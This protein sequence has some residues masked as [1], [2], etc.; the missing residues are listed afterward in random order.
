MRHNAERTDGRPALGRAARVQL[1]VDSKDSAR[2][3]SRMNAAISEPM[4]HSHRTCMDVTRYG[5][6]LSWTIDHPSFVAILSPFLT[7]DERGT[8]A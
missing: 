6:A 1:H 8:L 5:C 2:L 3:F 4:C 7:A